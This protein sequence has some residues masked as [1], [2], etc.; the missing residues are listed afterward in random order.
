VSAFYVDYSESWYFGS[1]SVN[2]VPGTLVGLITFT[3]AMGSFHSNA[4]GTVAG[5]SRV[6]VVD[7]TYTVDLNG[8]GTMTWLSPQ[9]GRQAPRFLHRQRRR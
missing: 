3:A 2:F 8:H 7:A 1:C 6:I 9:R 4:I 5:E